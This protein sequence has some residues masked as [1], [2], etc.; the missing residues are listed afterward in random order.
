MIYPTLKRVTVYAIH[1]LMK[2]ICHIFSGKFLFVICTQNT[3]G[4]N[5]HILRIVLNQPTQLATSKISIVIQLHESSRPRSKNNIY[6][7]LL[8]TIIVL[9][10]PGTESESNHL[11]PV[12]DTQST[13]ATMNKQNYYVT[14]AYMGVSTITSHLYN[15]IS[16]DVLNLTSLM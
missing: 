11:T 5:A 3:R 4:H 8:K 10:K 12:H 2:E 9:Q 1:R 7:S 16:T 6:S 13:C 15:T 14:R